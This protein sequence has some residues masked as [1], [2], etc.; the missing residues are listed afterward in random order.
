[1]SNTN[2]E[3]LAN[4]IWFKIGVASYSIYH[5]SK[6]SDTNHPLKLYDYCL[7]G[8]DGA[9]A[10]KCLE[11]MTS[12]ILSFIKPLKDYFI[13]SYIVGHVFESSGRFASYLARYWASVIFSNENQE[14]VIQ[15]LLKIVTLGFTSFSSI[16]EISVIIASAVLI[17]AYV[18]QKEKFKQLITDSQ[19]A[20]MMVAL[21]LS[22]FTAQIAGFYNTHLVNLVYGTLYAR[23]NFP[24]FKRLT[25][26]MI[27][28]ARTK[29]IK[30][31]YKKYIQLAE[32]IHKEKLDSKDNKSLKHYAISAVIG[33][34][35]KSPLFKQITD[36]LVQ[37]K[38]E[39][40]LNK[41]AGS[42][43]K[44]GKKNDKLDKK[45]SKKL[46]QPEKKKE[47]PKVE[48]QPP[49][50]PIVNQTKDNT[51]EQSEPPIEAKKET[52]SKKS[53]FR[54]P[55]FGSVSDSLKNAFGGST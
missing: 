53:K 41:W 6:N 21:I 23:R 14:I 19:R 30:P 31:I 42:E 9:F 2:G 10:G 38:I 11:G 33:G 49:I 43:D 25:D 54:K 34:R 44:E 22:V 39:Q 4:N 27:A 17:L 50:V 52:S 48:G 12:S 47:K 20:Q 45:Y 15:D 8:F 28:P 40:G 3:L 55:N 26:F 37:T 5:A 16:V 51:G 1:M 18:L 32:Q 46:P 29:I 7:S 24:C 36:P 13:D 35:Q